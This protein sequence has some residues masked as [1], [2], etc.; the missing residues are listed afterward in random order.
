MAAAIAE[1]KMTVSNVFFAGRGFSRTPLSAVRCLGVLTSAL[2]SENMAL[3]QIV[4]DGKETHASRGSCSRAKTSLFLLF[5]G[6]EF[7][8]T[9]PRQRKF[10]RS[11]VQA[12]ND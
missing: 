2:S 10:L 1:K 12:A 6:E 8:Q 9:E 3:R 5:A 4:S 7:Y 11:R